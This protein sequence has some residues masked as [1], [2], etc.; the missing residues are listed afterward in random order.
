MVSAGDALVDERQLKPPAL[1]SSEGML[2]AGAEE[3][4][5][6]HCQGLVLPSG[7]GTRYL[8][9]MPRAGLWVPERR[10]CR[11]CALCA[12]GGEASSEFSPVQNQYKPN[13]F[14]KS[15][16]EEVCRVQRQS[17]EAQDLQLPAALVAASNPEPFQNGFPHTSGSL[18]TPWG[19]NSV[20]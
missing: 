19:R 16:W 14:S 13:A 17:P 1:L 4:I 7:G 12:R 10:G 18:V 20:L 9:E 5:P 6:L 3:P 15:L 11:S 2:P 8:E